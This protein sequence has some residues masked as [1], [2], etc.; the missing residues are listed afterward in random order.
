MA[1]DP[2]APCPCGSGKKLKFCCSDIAD[3]IEKVYK[4]IEGDQPQAALKQVESL[5]AAKPDRASL[6][7]LK[8]S[9]ELSLKKLDAARETIVRF[10]LSH[11]DSPA[12][13]A[14]SAILEASTGHGRKG[15]APLQ[16]ALELLSDA[17]PQRVLEAVGAVGHALLMDGD[18]FAAR[19]HLLLYA[20]ISPEKDNAALDLLLRLNLESGLPLLLRQEYFLKP[21]PDGVEWKP[22]YD[23]VAVLSG[24]GLWRGAEQK[25]AELSA[26]H[27]GAPELVYGLALVRGWLGDAAGLAQGMHDY[28]RMEVPR[29]EA[30]EA[31]ALAQLVDPSI[32]EPSFGMVKRGYDVPDAD[33]LNEALTA[34]SRIEPYDL[35]E[36]ELGDQATRPRASFILLDREPVEPGVELGIDDVPNVVAFLSLYGK[37]TDRD[38]R[39]E[40]TTDAGE[41]LD[42]SASLLTEIAG[43]ELGDAGEDEVLAEKSHAEGALSWRWRLPERTPMEVRQRLLAERRRR[44]LLSDWP[45]SPLGALQGK[46]ADEARGD[47]ESSVAL[48][49]CVLLLEQASSDPDELPLFDELREQLGLAAVEGV[50]ADS[51][52]EAPLSRFTRY[53]AAGASV[54]QLLAVLQRASLGGASVAALLAAR[55]LVARSGDAGE[56]DLSAAFRQAIRLEPSP[57][58]AREHAEAAIAWSEARGRS[59]GEFRVALLEVAIS[60]GDVEQLE[61][62]LQ[63]IREKH[64]GEA[65]IAEAAYRVLF[66]AGLIPP[67]QAAP[68]GAGPEADRSGVWTPGQEP[69]PNG[70]EEKSGLWL[71]S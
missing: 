7:D 38:A 21:A 33:A 10:M 34:D 55:A 39:V 19:G 32:K 3:D 13:Q 64:A 57:T 58:R 50:A 12:A 20:G 31:E 30:V 24:R 54:E 36:Q 44:A 63:E 68:S 45:H 11:P 37:R 67:E 9:L 5:L 60:G 18:V 29:Q 66:S 49:A 51:G 48:E 4:K 17:M 25:L 15:I 59:A 35:T 47:E 65:E 42:R 23:E 1:M 2:Y 70:G 22:E 28:A 69:A 61:R 8:A 62:T 41:L 40:M 43:N 14:Q 6:I 52:G 71:P 26:K 16:N 56:A 53:D 27:T 46:T